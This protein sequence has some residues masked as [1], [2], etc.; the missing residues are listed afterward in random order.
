MYICADNTLGGFI[1]YHPSV[2]VGEV[3]GF[4]EASSESDLT[5]TEIALMDHDLKSIFE[6]SGLKGVTTVVFNDDSILV[7]GDL[8]IGKRIAFGGSEI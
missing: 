1:K 7:E 2:R 4:I 8:H 6:S 3:Y 5:E